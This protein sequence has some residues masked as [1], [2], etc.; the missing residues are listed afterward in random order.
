MDMKC[1]FTKGDKAFICENNIL[2][3]SEAPFYV[4]YLLDYKIKEDLTCITSN[5]NILI[6][7][8]SKYSLVAADG[9][10]CINKTYKE[11]YATEEWK[12]AGFDSNSIITVLENLHLSQD[13][14]RSCVSETMGNRFTEFVLAL[15]NQRI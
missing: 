15:K 1:N 11:T 4:K 9:F 6:N 2:I 3:S 5:R 14:I 12:N 7:T 8:D 10:H 13:Y